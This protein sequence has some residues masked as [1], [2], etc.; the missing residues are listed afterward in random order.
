[1]AKIICV[2]LGQ[3]DKSV[4]DPTNLHLSCDGKLFAYSK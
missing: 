4:L 1:M 3:L 2:R